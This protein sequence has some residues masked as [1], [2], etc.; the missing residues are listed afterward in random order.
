MSGTVLALALAL[1]WFLLVNLAASL[2][3]GAVAGLGAHARRRPTR[4]VSAGAWLCLRIS[5]SVVAAC[6]VALVYGRAY[7][8]FEPSHA[9][10]PFGAG[11]GTLVG[12]AML[13]IGWK[14]WCGIAAVWRVRSIQRSW[15]AG[16]RPFDYAGAPVPV[17]AIDVP[18][19]VVCLAGIRRQRLFVASHVLDALTQAE[20]DVVV[21]HELAHRSAWDNL[22]RLVL[23]VSPDLVSLTSI[24]SRIESAWARAA[25][26]AADERATGGEPSRAL[27]LSSAIL[28]VARLSLGPPSRRALPVSSFEDGGPIVERVRRLNGDVDQPAGPG[29]PRRIAF[30]LA[31]A[32]PF[33]FAVLPEST[34][35]S[36][37]RMT[38][39]LVR[40]A[41]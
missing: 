27:A 17:L 32:L 12:A 37:H 4:R 40:L 19:P 35:S 25:E 16:A 9:Y 28:K 8:R 39:F 6:F 10:E 5:P 29:R 13:V 1:A 30:G 22:R 24:G 33:V 20:L 15:L 7:A 36:V 26:D 11:L 18:R 14:A 2:V 23:L 31:V 38:E 34:L 3:V 41:S 21:A